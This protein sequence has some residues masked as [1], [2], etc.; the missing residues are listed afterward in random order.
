MGNRGVLDEFSLVPPISFRENLKFP[1]GIC[2]KSAMSLQQE[3]AEMHM[4]PSAPS[5]E[6]EVRSEILAQM[7]VKSFKRS[8]DLGERT[9]IWR[10]LA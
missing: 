2:L 5:E 7:G 9:R 10:I 6:R 3:Q 1:W 4:A 8:L